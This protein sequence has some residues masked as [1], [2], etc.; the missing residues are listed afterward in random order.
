M[1][2]VLRSCE[3]TPGAVTFLGTVCRK[4]AK[5]SHWRSNKGSF[6]DACISDIME[7][8]EVETLYALSGASLSRAG[9]PRQPFPTLKP[10]RRHPGVRGFCD[11]AKWSHPISEGGKESEIPR[12]NKILQ[13]EELKSTNGQ[14]LLG[15]GGSS[16]GFEKEAAELPAHRGLSLNATAAW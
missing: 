5:S 12:G 2:A 13:M 14:C 4:E 1:H 11:G 8:N 9:D 15:S 6:F 16:G 7:V 10:D 3:S